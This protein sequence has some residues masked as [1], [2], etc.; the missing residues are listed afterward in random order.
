[1]EHDHVAD[2]VR[3]KTK[4]KKKRRLESDVELAT[5]SDDRESCKTQKSSIDP[6]IVSSNKESK[7]KRKRECLSEFSEG[8]VKKN[9]HSVQTTTQSEQHRHREKCD[10]LERSRHSY[11][12]SP[13]GS[14]SLQ[15]NTHHSKKVSGGRKK[16]RKNKRT[17]D[18]TTNKDDL[19]NGNYNKTDSANLTM[20]KAKLREATVISNQIHETPS[21]SKERLETLAKQGIKVKKGKW[22]EE[23]K[24]L[25][26]FNMARYLERNNLSDPTK[27]L[28][29]SRKVMEDT[30]ERLYWL[31]FANDTDLY[32]ELGKGI[33]RELQSIT[34]CAR[35]ILTRQIMLEG[36]LKRKLKS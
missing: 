3:K 30:V 1:M 32:K 11:E 28:F 26:K 24:K 29:H 22:S 23:E 17:E 27:V 4:K 18:L 34:K 6:P 8:A 20:D 10:A 2:E 33:Q 5:T 7:K 25:L 12:I 13:S 14:S 16:K 21:L 31:R 19:A 15:S 9:K 35:R 36:T